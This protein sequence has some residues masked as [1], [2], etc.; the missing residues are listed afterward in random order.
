MSTFSNL[1]VFAEGGFLNQANDL[2]GKI[3]IYDKTAKR[4][5]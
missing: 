2:S 5:A 4:G 1:S 3:L